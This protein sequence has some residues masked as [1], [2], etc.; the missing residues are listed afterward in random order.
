[1]PLWM[2]SP[3]AR[4]CAVHGGS[5]PQAAELGPLPSNVHVEQWVPAGGPPP[6]CRRAGHGGSGTRWAPWP[7]GVPQAVLPVRRPAPNADRVE[8]L[9]PAW[10]STA[11]WW[12]CRACAG[13]LHSPTTLLPHCRR[14]C[15]G[16]DQL[17]P[18][19]DAAFRYS[20]DRGLRPASA[21][22]RVTAAPPTAR[23]PVPR[24]RSSDR[25]SRSKAHAPAVLASHLRQSSIGDDRHRVAHGAHHRQVGLRVR[26]GVR[27]GQVDPLAAGELGVAR[28]SHAVGERP[29][30][31]PV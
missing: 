11:D 23:R 14:P 21:G 8:S 25:P 9:A 28:L 22:G 2:P 26:V 27:G 10:P 6:R 12:R 13:A 1:M 5:A 7:G 15:G 3:C 20:G 31:S 30:G 24:R 29:V 4:A 16:R 18:A 17:S 19:V